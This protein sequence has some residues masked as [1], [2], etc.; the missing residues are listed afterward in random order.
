MPPLV[1]QEQ[2]KSQGILTNMVSLAQ[3]ARSASAWTIIGFGTQSALQLASNLVLTRIL[4]PEAFGLMAVA[5]V[6]L[7]GLAMF[8]DIGI[9]PSIVQNRDGENP[10]FLNTAWSIQVMRGFTLWAVACLIAWPV[11]II[12]EQPILFPLISVIGSTAAIS[13]F[14]TVM[15]ALAERRVIVGRVVVIQ[16]VGQLIS[17]VIT[18][19]LAWQYKSVWAL[20]YGAIAGSIISTFLGHVFLSGHTHQLAINRNFAKTMI[21]YGKWIFL[22]TLVSFMGGQG[23]R[24]IQAGLVS[25]S[26]IGII[27]IAQTFA[28]MPGDL[29]SRLLGSVAFPALSEANSRGFDQFVATLTKIRVYLLCFALPI[30]VMMAFSASWVIDFLYDNRYRDAAQ[31][32]AILCLGGAV[33][34][35]PMAYQNAFLA[36]GN[37]KLHFKIQALALASRIIGMLIGFHFNSVVGMLIGQVLGSCVSVFVV[38]IVANKKRISSIIIDLPA[39]CFILLSS[40]IVYEFYF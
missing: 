19:A 6:V 3:R 14:S 11:S 20:A 4:Y 8:S 22:G 34:V 2:P 37:S 36:I 29:T 12:Y 39:I 13:G 31:Y 26:T 33:T 18:A 17:I 15:L 9:K 25:M 38:Y 40:F 30:F 5:N 32:M 7:I 23:L 16:I 10:A 27:T 35:L 21:Q 24:A 28:W 1:D